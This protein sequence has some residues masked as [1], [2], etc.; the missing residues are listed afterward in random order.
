[1]SHPCRFR[2]RA[3]QLTAIRVLPPAARHVRTPRVHNCAREDISSAR[4]LSR[5]PPHVRKGGFGL[6]RAPIRKQSSGQNGE[7]AVVVL[8]FVCDSAREPLL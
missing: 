4:A 7:I 1:L 8:P 5:F 3:R 2:Y 6:R